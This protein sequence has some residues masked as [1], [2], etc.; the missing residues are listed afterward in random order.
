MQFRFEIKYDGS[1]RERWQRR[2]GKWIIE[3]EDRV[4]E[5]CM[6][7]SFTYEVNCV[8]TVNETRLRREGKVS[9]RNNYIVFNS[10]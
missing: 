3:Y 8:Q 4:G 5:I 7:M 2:E 1:L 6:E 10:S 9:W